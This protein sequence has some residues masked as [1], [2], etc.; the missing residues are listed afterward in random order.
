M[1]ACVA[2]VGGILFGY[3]MGVISGAKTQMQAELG[4]TCAQVAAAVAFLPL[5]GFVASLVGGEENALSKKVTTANYCQ[6]SC[7]C[8]VIIHRDSNLLNSTSSL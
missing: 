8:Q 5:G 7:L 6:F 1:A 4:L 2:A 3:D